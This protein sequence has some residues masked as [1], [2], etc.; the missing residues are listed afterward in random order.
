MWEEWKVHKGTN[1]RLVISGRDCGERDAA[2]M[3][4]FASKNKKS[5]GGYIEL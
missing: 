1:G 3:D 2:G 5:L 4:Y